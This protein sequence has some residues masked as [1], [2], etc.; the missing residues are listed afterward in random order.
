M[1]NHLSTGVW[2][3]YQGSHPSKRPA[4]LTPGS[5]AVSGPQFW[6]KAHSVPL[7]APYHRFSVVSFR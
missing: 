7:P 2:L 4:L 6:M 3:T 5:S 1:C